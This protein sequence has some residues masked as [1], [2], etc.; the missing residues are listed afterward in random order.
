MKH[1]RQN[2][3]LFILFAFSMLM[4]AACPKPQEYSKIPE[5][6]FKQVKLFNSNDTLGNPE[7]TYQM[8][9][10]LIDGD[11]NIGL[12]E[13]DT[14]GLGTDSLYVNNVLTKMFEVKNGDTILTDS[15]GSYNFRIPNIEP[16]G[17][18]ELLIAD[19]FIDW[20][21]PYYSDTLLFDSIFFEFFIIDKE[22]NKSNI[23]ETPVLYLDTVGDFPILLNN[24]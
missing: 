14:I 20:T 17:Q 7:K 13:G 3:F 18:N 11:G 16:L 24:E 23:S 21:F 2:I 1:T 15:T 22:L 5:I 9:F 8:K 10:G 6:E 12:D 4:F 19:I